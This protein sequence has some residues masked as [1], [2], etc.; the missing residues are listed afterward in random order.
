MPK[1]YITV[2]SRSA[3]DASNL[4][5]PAPQ[6]PPIA[7]YAVE[8][9]LGKSNQ[10]EAFA[11]NATFVMVKPDIA[12]CLGFGENPKAIDGVH[13]LD[14]GEIRWYGVYPRHK[15]AVIENS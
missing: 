3:R 8:I 4:I 13:S 10:S 11:Q 6:V 15:I 9:E 14:A 5:V 7:E 12:C 2:Y 1:L